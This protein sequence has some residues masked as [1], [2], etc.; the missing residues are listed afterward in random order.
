MVS[1]SVAILFSWTFA[2]VVIQ[3]EDF[4]LF[5]VRNQYH[6]TEQKSV[7][8]STR[9]K[10]SETAI[11]IAS[12]SGLV[13]TTLCNLFLCGNSAT[14]RSPCRLVCIPQCL[15]RQA[16]LLVLEL[17]YWHS[18]SIPITQL[19]RSLHH[20]KRLIPPQSFP[21]F[22]D[23]FSPPFPYLYGEIAPLPCTCS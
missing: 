16:A 14:W 8:I 17:Q 19:P 6:P 12:C 15:I 22:L 3:D 10:R 13:L 2:V 1:G 4:S 21:P 9:S 7:S 20:S 18:Q 5:Y 23:C 11:C